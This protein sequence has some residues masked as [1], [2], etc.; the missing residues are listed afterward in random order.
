MLTKEQAIEAARAHIEQAYAHRLPDEAPWTLVVLPDKSYAYCAGWII[1]YDSE[2]RLKSGRPW[3][4]PFTKVLI[5]PG[6]GSA[7]YGPP[8]NASVEEFQ[9]FRDT[10]VWPPHLRASS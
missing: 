8:T 3:D 4:G 5:V 9:Q 6:D 10:G 2:E 1:W 7:P